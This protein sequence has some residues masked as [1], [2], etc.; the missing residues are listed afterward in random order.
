MKSVINIIVKICFTF[1]FSISF[2]MAAGDDPCTATPLTVNATCVYSL[3]DN[4]GAT[5]TSGVS[6]PNCANFINNDVWFSIVVP[7]NGSLII[8]S[9]AGTMTN[10]AIALYTGICTNLTQVAC[11]DN[12]STNSGMGII[13]RVGLTPGSTVYLRFWQPTGGS[14]TFSLCAQTGPNQ[15]SNDNCTGATM[16]TVNATCIATNASVYGSSQS[17]QSCTGS[18]AN[19]VWFSFIATQTSH[20]IS[21]TPAAGFNPVVEFFS[22]SCA[23]LTSISC[24]DNSFPNGAV[25]TEIFS[26]LTIGQTYFYRVYQTSTNYPTS[27][28]GSF[29]T[30]VTTLPT[31]P[32]NDNCSGAV[33]LTVNSSCVTT[34]GTIYG[35]TESFPGCTSAAY[36]DVW[37][38]FVAT[39]SNILLSL[40]S[41]ATIGF[42]PIVELFSGSC[43]NLTSI[44]CND[45][46]FYP[47]TVSGSEYYTGLTIG[48][49]Y[50]VRVYKSIQVYPT[51]ASGA[52]TICVSTI[53]TPTNDNCSGA[54]NLTV[55]S[56]C[57]PTTGT[58]Y[59]ATQ[60]MPGCFGN[61]NDDVWY[62]FVASQTSVMIS[63]TTVASDLNSDPVVELFSGTCGNLTSMK[64]NDASFPYTTSG[65]DVF[66]GLTIGQTYYY[67]VY[68]K[69][70]RYPNATN[71][72]FTTCVYTAPNSPVNDNCSGA[73]TVVSGTTC[74][75]ISA[76][77]YGATESMPGCSGNANDDVWFIFVATN[78]T[79]IINVTPVTG[80][81]T[82]IVELFSGTCGNLTS[83][84]CNSTS[85]F[86]SNNYNGLFSGLTVGQ[87]YFYRV[88]QSSALYPTTSNGGFTT[89]VT[90]STTLPPSN[91]NCINATSLTV[92]STCN[93]TNGT[94]VGSTPSQVAPPT[95]FSTAMAIYDVWYSFTATQIY[96][97]INV[98]PT[99]SGTI[100]YVEVFSGNCTNLNSVYCRQLTSSSTNPYTATVDNLTPG[101]I[102]FYRLIRST[103][104]IPTSTSNF[105]TCV[106]STLPPNNQDCLGAI[107]LCSS[108]Y[109]SATAYSGTGNINSEIDGNPL[110]QC[111]PGEKNNVWYTFNVIQ[112]GNLS[113]N[114]SPNYLL[115]DY[116][117]AVFNLTNAN[118]SDINN[119]ASLLVACNYS[120]ISGVTGANGLMG[121]QNSPVIPV[122]AGQ[123]YVININQ[124]S[125]STNGYTIDFSASTATIFDNIAPV[126]QSVSPQSCGSS[127]ISA[128]FSEN[129]LCSTVSPADFTL[130]GPDGAHTVTSLSGNGCSVGGTM[131]NTY[132]LTFNPP[133]TV[134][135]TYTISLVAS[136][137]SVTDLCGNVA[138][139]QSFNFDISTISLNATVTQAISCNGGNNGII[140]TT[141]TGGS[142]PYSYSWSAT[143]GLTGSSQTISNATAGD[144]SITVNDAAG[145]SG[146]ATITL[147][148]PTVISTQETVIQPGCGNQSSV[149][150]ATSGGTGTFS[151]TWTPNV[152]STSSVTNIPAGNYSIVV[153]DANG[154][155]TTLTETIDPTTQI[156]AIINAQNP[157][158]L[159]GNSFNFSATTSSTSPV[160]SW[161]F[162]DNSVLNTSATPNHTYITFGTYQ[163][164]L[165]VSNGTCADTSTINVIV[166]ENPSSA[167]TGTNLTCFNSANGSITST[168]AG[169]VAPYIYSWNTVLG[170]T[171]S[172]IV[173]NL[174]AGT[175]TLGVSDANGCQANPQSITISE[176]TALVVSLTS[177]NPTCTSLGSITSAVSG[178]TGTYT[179]LWSPSNETTTS[180]SNL[181]VGN[182][183]LTVTDLNGCSRTSSSQLTNTSTITATISPLTGQCLSGNQFSFSSNITDPAATYSWNF[184]DNSALNTTAYPTYSYASAGNFTVGLT[185]TLGSCTDTDNATINVYSSPVAQASANTPCQGSN[186]LLSGLPSGMANYAWTGPTSSSVQNPVIP[187]CTNALVGTYTLT[188]TDVNGCIGTTTTNVV[189]NGLPS[190]SIIGTNLQGCTPIE[191]EF[192]S[193]NQTY[194]SYLWNYGDG[195][196]A[197]GAT[198]GHLY[199]K[200]G[201]Y[202]VSLTI[203]DAN[204]CSNVI[205]QP[206]Y[207]QAYGLPTASFQISSPNGENISDPIVY[208][209]DMSSEDVTSWNWNFGDNSPTN[210]AS[211]S[212]QNPN[213][214]YQNL[215]STYIVTL[216][217][218]N[219]NGCNDTIKQEIKINEPLLY[220]IPNSFT[221][222]GDKFN[223]VFAPVF[224]SG[225]DPYDY[226]MTIYNRWGELIFE[227]NDTQVGWD[228]TYGGKL[229]Q[230]G[231]YVWSIQFG[232][233]A[234][235]SRKSIN[236]SLNLMK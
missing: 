83:I 106:T 20:L 233:L 109:S 4:N 146:S 183:S 108:V 144:Y 194:V 167:L 76:T 101:Q 209:T 134:S 178:G 212:I 58:F 132:S 202:T 95:C 184:G 230:D 96:Q 52:F 172:S 77:V 148:E 128:T 123:T 53:P 196:S 80:F 126:F 137:G 222:D 56:T 187:N 218:S 2:L 116:D 15:V 28:N 8:D 10:G 163:V 155:S 39:Q 87:T 60:S 208:F 24:N 117:W 11:E 63:L 228:G 157:Q 55:G 74:T 22:G 141:A 131:E 177:V 168:V 73:I 220:Y 224:T 70:D 149:S 85:Y 206:D 143:N 81:S 173:S 105:T 179:Y 145:C 17:S 57:T 160:Y 35:A 111:M 142:I 203:T 62:S 5:T 161:D 33:S 79:Q 181:A 19:D 119:D 188:I 200:P 174:T 44:N 102:Y 227:S 71:S 147:T 59:G 207:V 67:R 175:Y 169:G 69:S 232:L 159:T 135:G 93:P 9:Q 193:S 133:V 32:L 42:N 99:T 182:Y 78:T 191:S 110:G 140:T 214:S 12:N 38:S 68:Q 139:P 199:S 23:G 204:G 47:A 100:Y 122:L 170:S 115:E 185:V 221:P 29:S 45:P 34:N 46:S 89:C 51:T 25:G 171:S 84:N 6:I 13:T 138:A 18:V 43:G 30:C 121:N 229:V 41:P 103:S 205:T 26:G 231:T 31:P 176:P 195:T 65:S 112:S 235:D 86:L 7:A 129:V 40:A 180:I 226:K 107:P 197:T 234:D 130:V 153:T 120:G 152:S 98:T 125:S 118:C 92:G 156:T 75:P 124:Y 136:S 198:G 66:S 213:H 186:L 14:G 114:I 16:L 91:D 27:A 190:A 1:L 127:T 158:C 217:V 216:V 48:Q 211:N 94:F 165:I 64:C 90:E 3:F 150:I 164:T 88:Y 225:F 97:N 189:M 113:F 37:Y 219:E 72:T 210:T 166:N 50:Y 104:S 192:E 54:T 201:V 223:Q 162:G 215:G 61:A 154:C 21:V 82:P 36:N 151:Y 49:T 236:G